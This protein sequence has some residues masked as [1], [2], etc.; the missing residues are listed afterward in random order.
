[1]NILNL[2]F[3]K[4][5]HKPATSGSFRLERCLDP[6]LFEAL[7][8]AAAVIDREYHLVHANPAFERMFGSWKNRCCFNVYKKRANACAECTSAVVFKD[9]GARVIDEAGYNRNGRPIKYRQRTTPII[10]NSGVVTHLLQ[11]VTD[12]TEYEQ[13]RDDYQSLFDRVPCSILLIN[14]DFRIVKTNETF[15]KTV[16]E[17]EGKHCYES[18]K[19]LDH[20]CAEC[21]AR[22]TFDDGMRHSG[23]HVWKTKDGRTVHTHVITVPIKNVDGTFDLVM[24]MAVDVSHTVKLHDGLIFAHKFLDAI[25]TSSLDGIFAVNKKGKVTLFN[26]AAR[27]L[28]KIQEDQIV[29]RSELSLMLPKGFLA[30]VSETPRH[31]CLPETLVQSLSGEPVPVRLTG[32]RLMDDHSPIGMAFTVMDLRERKQLERD[33]LEAER[34]A[35]VGQTVAGLAHG[36]K[37]LITALE[38][39]MYML[40]SGLKNGR[41]ERI[42]QGME[43][44]SRNID[45]I[46]IFVKAFLSFSKGREIQ[47]KLSNPAEIAK[48]VVDLYAVKA[49][50]LGIQ[51]KNEC[52]RPV[53]PAPID[54][55]SMHECLTNL[56]GNAID[57]CQVSEKGGG[58]HVTVRTF[59]KND[60]ILYEV[61]DD[62]TGMDYEV[63]KKVFTTFFTT[64]GLGGSGL[65]LLMTKKIVQEHGGTIDLDSTPGEGSLFR[66]TLPRN[67][68]PKTI[69]GEPTGNRHSSRSAA[70]SDQK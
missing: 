62:G 37:N 45:R 66:I 34:L 64:K 35:A 5:R 27:H 32:H 53:K 29:S 15:R 40:G 63:Q 41:I 67:R 50:S 8:L 42:Q 17:I 11:L 46:S 18:L 24:E 13:Y 19:G 16:G 3:F 12:I 36:V 6:E 43:M 59:E 23:Y 70:P 54:Y 57:A 14:K 4:K 22:Q 1:M 31:V 48:E 21:T 51:L 61:I 47:V 65:G 30:S 20:K 56:V 9:G 26:P 10:D 25:V 69:P 49:R 52:D 44:L 38:G 7:P 60:A 58:L 2:S 55:E 33:K 68:L 39:G 28:F